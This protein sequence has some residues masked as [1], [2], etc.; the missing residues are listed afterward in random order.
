MNEQTREEKRLIAQMEAQVKRAGRKTKETSKAKYPKPIK[1]IS[2]GREIEYLYKAEIS[3]TKQGA[4]TKKITWY[5]TAEDIE[6]IPANDYIRSIGKKELIEKIMGTSI[7]EHNRKTGKGEERKLSLMESG[8]F[9][10]AYLDGCI[11]HN[12]LYLIF[13]GKNKLNTDWGE[14]E[15]RGNLI[16]CNMFYDL[17]ELKKEIEKELTKP[18]TFVK[19]TI[20]PFNNKDIANIPTNPVV[21]GGLLSCVCKGRRWKKD[22]DG[23]P[24]YLHELKGAKLKGKTK[25]K[26]ACVGNEGE[27]SFM[28]AKKAWE[29]VKSLGIKTAKLHILCLAYSMTKETRKAKSFFVEKEKIY[30]VLGLD[31]RNDL[32][33]EEK[34]RICFEEIKK[35]KSIA[36]QFYYIKP[37]ARNEK[38]I[39]FDMIRNRELNPLWYLTTVDEGQGEFNFEE[40]NGKGKWETWFLQGKAGFWADDF[41]WNDKTWN[42]YGQILLKQITQ[43]DNRSWGAILSLE[44]TFRLRINSGKGITNKEIIELCGEE[45]KPK[46][47]GKKFELKEQVINAIEEQRKWGFKPIYDKW[48]E[49]LKPGKKQQERLPRNYWEEFLH[50]ETHFNF[51]EILQEVIDNRKLLSSPK[52]N[53][54]PKPR[55]K[56]NPWTAERIKQLRKKLKLSQKELAGE[57]GISRPMLT[58]L[59]A[60]KRSIQKKHVKALY[61]LEK[62][63]KSL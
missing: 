56:E 26:I 16:T 30:K 55:A 3:K 39:K 47:R 7:I 8:V 20:T 33:K 42:P 27:I 14:I 41:L 45:V 43:T 31:K 62:K 38:K 18:Q 40:R 6:Q 58:L 4:N 60:G 21:Y 61:G 32:P 1:E 35:L 49:Y 50:C 57:M 28:T 25:Y 24:C 46:D 63:A 17:D 15:Q 29:I 2:E 9:V 51:P 13:T 5:I 10:E 44:I 52:E 36:T 34:D 19:P 22:E 23:L 48:Y 54:I 53:Y 11:S 12:I 37:T 59:E